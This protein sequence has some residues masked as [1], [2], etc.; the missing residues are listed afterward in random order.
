MDLDRSEPDHH[1]GGPFDLRGELGDTVKPQTQ[2]IFG[3]ENGNCFAACLASILELPVDEVPNFCETEDW[4]ERTNKWLEPRGLF[5]LAVGIPEEEA[6]LLH[7]NRAGY[8]VI[9]GEGPRNCPHSVVG[10]AGRMVHDPH[11]S[12]AGLERNLEYGFLIPL[13]PSRLP[14]EEA[15]ESCTVQAGAGVVQCQCD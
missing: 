2:T 8:H 4:V 7:L 1:C 11:P 10:F 5:F 13:N 12:G 3:S 15:I 9:I 6:V 14:F